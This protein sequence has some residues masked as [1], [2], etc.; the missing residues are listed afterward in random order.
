M[1]G[2]ITFWYLVFPLLLLAI[3]VIAHIVDPPG[4]E[5]EV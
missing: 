2:G 5:K 1:T 3:A 4:P